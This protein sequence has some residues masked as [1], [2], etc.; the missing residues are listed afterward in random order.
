MG[1]PGDSEVKNPLTVQEEQEMQVWS[2]DQEDP[3][4]QGMETHSNSPSG[5]IS[6]AEKSGG[7]QSIGLQ[8][9]EN[10]TEA[11]EHSTAQEKCIRKANKPKSLVILEGNFP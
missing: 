1:F 3:L 11:T 8:R 4:E 2:L 9:V 10:M 6:W 7:L 5:K